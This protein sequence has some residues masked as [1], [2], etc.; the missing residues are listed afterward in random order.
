MLELL[1][2]GALSFSWGVKEH[3]VEIRANWARV[4]RHTA[5]VAV[6]WA[7]FFTVPLQGGGGHRPS[8]TELV[9]KMLGSMQERGAVLMCLGQSCVFCSSS[10]VWLRV[11]GGNT[12]SSHPFTGLLLGS[13][14][15][16]G[17]WEEGGDEIPWDISVPSICDLIT[18]HGVFVSSS[19][20]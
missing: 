6:A 13:W 4:C 10:A 5:E 14:L 16:D 8:W 1:I 18:V 17:R 20:T 7:G 15:E 3:E 9:S 11:Q 19:F 2:S 12:G